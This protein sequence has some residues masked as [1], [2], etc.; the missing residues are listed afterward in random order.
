MLA[1]RVKGKP[2]L[3]ITWLAISRVT[4]PVLS[5]KLY[6]AFMP[7]KSAKITVKESNLIY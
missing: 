4:L 3:K 7:A 5:F 1:P 2:K 6:P